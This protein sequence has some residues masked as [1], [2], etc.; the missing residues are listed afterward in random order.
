[1]AEDSIKVDPNFLNLIMMLQYSAMQTMG[2]IASPISGKVERDLD[3]CRMSIDMLGMIAEKT[4]GNL[5]SDE[6][7]LIDS[8]LYNLRMNF[9]EEQKKP[10]AGKSGDEAGAQKESG[11]A[12]GSETKS[13]ED[14]EKNQSS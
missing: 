6:Q 9:L 1:M 13:A 2:K 8:I 7:K 14:E 4:R 5:S 11:V 3:Q 10:A 12:E